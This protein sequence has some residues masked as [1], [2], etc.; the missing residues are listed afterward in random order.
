MSEK[1]LFTAPSIMI[2]RQ[3]ATIEGRSFAVSQI[4]SVGLRTYRRQWRNN[5]LIGL[6]LLAPI[7]YFHVF[8]I[9]CINGSC[10]GDSP[11]WAIMILAYI[12]F[13][14]IIG[15]CFTGVGAVQLLYGAINPRAGNFLEIGTS[16]GRVHQI[17]G[18][19][20]DVAA[21]VEAAIHQAISLR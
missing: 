14:G 17:K 6:M 4:A 7:A 11:P 16:D 19:A 3:M 13:G 8:N 12:L 18:M 15:L 21:S 2:T 9:G 5:L 10:G 20:N 1:T